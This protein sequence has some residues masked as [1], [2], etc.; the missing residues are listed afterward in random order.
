[1]GFCDPSCSDVD[2]SS[3]GDASRLGQLLLGHE[4]P[5]PKKPNFISLSASF[6]TNLDAL[7]RRSLFLLTLRRHTHRPVP[8]RST[9]AAP[10]QDALILRLIVVVLVGVAV[11]VFVLVLAPV[12][13]VLAELVLDYLISAMFVVL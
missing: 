6:V 11:I 8:L 9:V 5:T 1:M 2:Q 3:V 7:L 13:L 12:V 4:V 10:Q